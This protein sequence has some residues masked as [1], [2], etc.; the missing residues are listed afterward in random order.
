M[1]RPPELVQV[2]RPAGPHNQTLSGRK[3]EGIVFPAGGLCLFWYFD[4]LAPS[5]LQMKRAI[6]SLFCLMIP[7]AL[8]AQ[9]R[10]CT[11]GEIRITD[12]PYSLKALSEDSL[13]ARSSLLL[14]NSF[15]GVIWRAGGG[16]GS[17][18]ISINGA[19]ASHTDISWNGIPF[20]NS[21]LGQADASLLSETMLRN[22]NIRRGGRSE[23]GFCS[24][25]GGSL[26]LE[27]ERLQE[28]ENLEL[29]A[30]AGSFGQFRQSALFSKKQKLS[31]LN[32][33]VWNQGG[34][35]NYPYE[36]HGYRTKLGHSAR[37]FS[38]LEGSLSLQLSPSQKLESGIWIQQ[39]VREIPGVL[40][41]DNP[42]GKQTDENARAFVRHVLRKNR[43]EIRQMLG[44]SRD[45]LHY[46]DPKSS[47]DNRALLN[48]FYYQANSES[49]LRNCRLLLNAHL[50]RQNGMQLAHNN[51]IGLNR[52]GFGVSTAIPLWQNRLLLLP[53]LKYELWNFQPIRRTD[54]G[55]LPA[56]TLRWKGDKGHAIE[57]GF[58]RKMRG[59]GLNDL[60]WPLAGN[61]DL[62]S[63]KGYNVQAVWNYQIE[64]GERIRSGIQSGLYH[65]RIENYI[66]W[67]PKGFWWHPENAG[68]AELQGLW[69]RP[70][71]EFHSR[72]GFFCIIEAET[73][74]ARQILRQGNA[75]KGESAKLPLSPDFQSLT[76]ISAG[77]KL[78][79]GS[80][81]MTHT[82]SRSEGLNSIRE[83]MQAFQLFDA[84]LELSIPMEKNTLSI[85][86][87]AGNLLN[88]T[89]RLI[90]AWPMPGR[91]FSLNIS[92]HL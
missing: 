23:N 87:E 68:V 15:P 76:S 69:F 74:I 9:E 66:L 47:T 77:N 45:V 78:L 56:A 3:A 43:H 33:R 35:W 48:G 62:K 50:S 12:H 51:A 63:E 18:G 39:S 36:H 61:P 85:S 1:G 13:P 10:S 46:Q 38:G 84:G 53:E 72:S 54:A 59:P 90:P 2:R 20:S 27:S 71:V 4:T 92:L 89:Y 83:I 24:S 44:I 16:S 25:F 41:E 34:L 26:I 28:G 70:E 32:L 79:K 11:L 73:R 52:S 21:F 82:G 30:G 80:I 6:F 67:Q 22:A 86:M 88:T 42:E 60:F 37:T 75:G 58:Y 40:F 29:S 49:R 57:L 55:L 91:N 17:S 8:I 14:L 7:P 19:Q 64:S 31:G 5:L 65:T 81:R